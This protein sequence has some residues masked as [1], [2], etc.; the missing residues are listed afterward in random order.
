MQRRKHISAL[1]KIKMMLLLVD[2]KYP[3]VAT[4]FCMLS[5]FSNAQNTNSPNKTAAMGVEVN[6][7]TGNL[8]L[9]RT[10]IY[11]PGR[12]LDFDISFSYNSYGYTE[13]TGY[14]NGWTFKYNEFDTAGRF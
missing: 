1:S 14:G 7:R 5:F 4:I 8:F 13:N 9:S 11:I 10:D 3:V 6:T 12:Q 2:V